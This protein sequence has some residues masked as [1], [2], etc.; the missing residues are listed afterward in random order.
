MKL[1]DAY[2]VIE[3]IYG[4]SDETS[5]AGEAWGVVQEEITRLSA[6]NTRLRTALHDA[7][8]RP[9]GVVPD[10]AEEFYG[11]PKK[12]TE[13]VVCTAGDNIPAEIEY[14][15]EEGKVVGFWAY[16]CWHPDYPYRGEE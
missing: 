11:A 12:Y 3:S 10:S 5:S 13:H 16:G 14:R 2:S 1:E 6:E 4:F 9:M 8:N 15:D 7:I